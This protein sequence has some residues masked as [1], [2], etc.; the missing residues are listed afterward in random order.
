MCELQDE[1]QEGKGLSSVQFQPDISFL[2]PSPLPCRTRWG[3]VIVSLFWRRAGNPTPEGSPVVF[4]VFN[5]EESD[6]RSFY[7]R[8]P[9]VKTEPVSVWAVFSAICPPEL[10]TCL[11]Q[12]VILMNLRNSSARAPKKSFLNRW[13]N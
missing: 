7:S 8:A 13:T 1:S 5:R 3:K 12:E 11:G 9:R 4:W 6:L 10:Q 2:L